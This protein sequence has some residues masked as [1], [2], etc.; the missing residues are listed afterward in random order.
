MKKL[1]FES[2]TRYIITSSI[3]FALL[4]LPAGTIQYPNAWYVLL[5]FFAPVFV[6]GIF[7]LI[8][9]PQLLQQRL[10]SI[11]YDKRQQKLTFCAAVICIS[12]IVSSGITWKH[13]FLRLSNGFL[14]AGSALLILSYTVYFLALSKNPFLSRTVSVE[15]GQCVVDTGIYGIIRHPFY[16]GTAA[17]CLSMAFML[18]ALICIFFALV[19]T[20]ILFLRIKY[21]EEFLK[22][23]L[24]GYREYTQK[25]KYR[26]LPYIW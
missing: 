13:N 2:L 9:H 4:F 23:E 17:S 18:Q 7:L 5:S 10:K 1:V 16:L 12:G 21:E 14:I 26:L 25:V 15:K 24:S 8:F 22:K 20:P 19:A 6:C 3:Y 11:E